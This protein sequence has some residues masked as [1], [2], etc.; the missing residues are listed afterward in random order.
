M[1]FVS[2]VTQPYGCMLQLLHVE[3]SVVTTVAG[4]GYDGF[5]PHTMQH[6]QSQ[7]CCSGAGPRLAAA[8]LLQWRYRAMISGGGR[9][10]QLYC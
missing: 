2:Q 1:Q 10:P 6:L 3:L 7:S 4:V 9:G 8:L 5:L